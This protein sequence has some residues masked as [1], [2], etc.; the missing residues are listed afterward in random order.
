MSMS[1]ENNCEPAVPDSV[2]GPMTTEAA[3]SVHR[4]EKPLLPNDV[5][6]HITLTPGTLDL[7]DFRNQVDEHATKRAGEARKRYAIPK[8]DQ[9]SE[10]ERAQATAERILGLLSMSRYRRGPVQFIQDA[11][12]EFLAKLT[13]AI[14]ADRPVE[15][16]LSFFGYKVQNPLK[17]FAETGSEV[18]ISEMASLLRFYEIS[19]AI[20]EMYPP[21]AV[22]HIACDGK[23]YAYAFGYGE[24]QA[25][26][27]HQNLHALCSALGIQDSVRLLDETSFYPPDHRERTTKHLDR[28]KEG[29]LQGDAAITSFVTKLRASICLSI[30]VDTSDIGVE[31]VRLA[32]SVLTDA[33]LGAASPRAFEIRRHFVQ[34]S[35]NCTLRYIAVYDAIKEAGAINHIAPAA[36]RATVHPK[37][38]QIGL[39]AVNNATN[40]V[41]P[42]HGQGIMQPTQGRMAIDG[43]RVRFRADLERV[44]EMSGICLPEDQFSFGS[45]HHPFVLVP[46]S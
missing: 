15:M 9:S 37:S 8:L 39:Y 29:F 25:A 16:V 43:V 21:G 13:E 18:D 42:H 14:L 2:P 27:Y 40:D 28:V 24:D 46:R 1:P 41:F 34:E 4:F 38:G 36:L 11:K 35:L 22:I 12:P 30:P 19:Q 6:S 5:Y 44:P 23:K 45:N 7:G 31:E 17:T 3:I 20:R 26:G 33:E 32:F 10:L